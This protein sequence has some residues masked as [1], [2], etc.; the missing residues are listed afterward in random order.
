MLDLSSR[1][2]HQKTFMVQ[3]FRA[4]AHRG[5]KTIPLWVTEFSRVLL[6]RWQDAGEGTSPNGVHD[7]RRDDARRR[8]AAG[9]SHRMFTA[10]AASSASTASEINA[11]SI[12]RIFAQCDRTAVSVG[13]NAVLVLKAR[14]R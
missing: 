1:T 14:N 13:E 2:V 5:S 12:V 4:V 11:C 10:R 7:R 3:L 6:T 8:C 9:R